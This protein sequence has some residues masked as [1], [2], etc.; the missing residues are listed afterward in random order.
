MSATTAISVDQALS[1]SHRMNR[2]WA[3]RRTPTPSTA[4]NT[5]RRHTTYAVR[6]RGNRMQDCNLFDGD[7][8]IIRRCQTGTAEET[9]SAEINHQPIKL[10]RLIIDRHGLYL[11]VQDDSLSAIYLRN[12]DIQVLNLVMGVEH[13][14]TEH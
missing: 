9:A 13:Y 4:N 5:T 7:V 10:Q 8:I 14:L 6:V 1:H 12:Q 2:F 11:V 3:S